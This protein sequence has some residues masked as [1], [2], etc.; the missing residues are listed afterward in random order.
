MR[1]K[2]KLPPFPVIEAS[3]LKD[4]AMVDGLMQ[5]TDEVLE[6]E[7]INATK[8]EGWL[9]S[10]SEGMKTM[11]P[12]MVEPMAAAAV[13]SRITREIIAFCL[14]LHRQ[15]KGTEAGPPGNGQEPGPGKGY[16]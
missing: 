3:Q 8:I 11:D 14:Y 13:H 10:C 7:L 16:L 15:N 6:I 4:M 12:T 2:K 9:R 5:S 1:R